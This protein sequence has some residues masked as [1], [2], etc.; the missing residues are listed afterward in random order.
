MPTHYYLLQASLTIT[1]S[2][3]VHLPGA[4][5]GEGMEVG[6]AAAVVEFDPLPLVKNPPAVIKDSSRVTLDDMNDPKS[7]FSA[8][9]PAACQVL[10]KNISGELNKQPANRTCCRSVWLL[11]RRRV[12]GRVCP[13]A[14]R[15]K[16]SAHARNHV[17]K[18]CLNGAVQ[19]Q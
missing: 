3:G 8:D 17:C 15:Q 7:T 12:R 5:G 6:D 16:H 4:G 13:A 2:V 1:K 19:C 10:Y 18:A 9:L 14:I 11:Q